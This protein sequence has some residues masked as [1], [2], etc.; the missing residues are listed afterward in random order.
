MILDLELQ[1][2]RSK[3]LLKDNDLQIQNY[4]N[5]IEDLKKQKVNLEGK[6]YK[7]ENQ[8]NIIKERI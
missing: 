5:T 2:K 7:L 4:K 8:N 6:N 3:K 1:I